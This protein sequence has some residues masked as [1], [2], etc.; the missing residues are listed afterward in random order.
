MERRVA[1]LMRHPPVA[2]TL[3]GMQLRLARLCLDCEEVHDAQACP[4]CA[5]EAFAYLTR[6]VPTPDRPLR[7]RPPVP[8]PV[9]SRGRKV[10]TWLTGGVVGMT[11]LGIAGWLWRHRDDVASRDESRK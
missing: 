10:G 6:W 5:S 1:V 2:D 4:L 7:S 11:A 3:S 9:E 8:P